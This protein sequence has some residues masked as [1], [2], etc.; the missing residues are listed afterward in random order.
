MPPTN[1]TLRLIY[2]TPFTSSYSLSLNETKSFN[3]DEIVELP[4]VLRHEHSYIGFPDKQG[5]GKEKKDA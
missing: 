4:H 3:L 1:S 5:E 2:F